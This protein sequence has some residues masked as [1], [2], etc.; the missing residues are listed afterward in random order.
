MTTARP[1][2]PTAS[3]AGGCPTVVPGPVPFAAT[4]S[5]SSRP[6]TGGPLGVR[7]A[8]TGVH[9][10]YD[11]VVI[12]L[13][14]RAA[15]TPGWRVAYVARPTSDAS[16]RPVA[17]RGASFLQV[18]VTGVGY[19]QDTGVPGPAVTRLTPRCTRVVR[20]V[21]LDGVF[22]GS[23][24]AFVGLSRVRPFRVFGLA[25]PARVVVDVR[26]G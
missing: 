10:G 9:P 18:T 14:G 1:A 20:Q 25:H 15:G 3:P 8:T 16:G 23:Y 24:T 21:V 5:P 12:T 13:A 26:H 19:P 17:V 6:A 11:R 4:T 2:T 7:G 22:E